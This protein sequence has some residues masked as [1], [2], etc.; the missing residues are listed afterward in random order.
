M[1]SH[2]RIEKL[3]SDMNNA[4]MRDPFQSTRTP[5]WVSPSGDCQLLDDVFNDDEECV[6]ALFND[7]VFNKKCIPDKKDTA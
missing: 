2:I 3:V 6:K 5:V 4:R 1:K 7:G